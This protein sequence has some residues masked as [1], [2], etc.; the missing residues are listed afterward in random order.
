MGTQSPA[1]ISR[2]EFYEA[3]R[4]GPAKPSP[5]PR[6]QTCTSPPKASPR[7]SAFCLSALSFCF[8]VGT[9]NVRSDGFLSA[10]TARPRPALLCGRPLRPSAV[11]RAWHPPPLPRPPQPRSVLRI[12]KSVSDAS[13]EGIAEYLSSDRLISLSKMSPGALPDVTSGRK[14]CACKAEWRPAARAGPGLS[15][16][17]PACGRLGCLL[18][19]ANDAAANRCGAGVSPRPWLRFLWTDPA[20]E[21]RIAGRFCLQHSEA[22][23]RCRP[24]RL[25]HLTTRQ[26]STAASFSA[27]SATLVKMSH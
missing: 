13:Y 19:L 12:C 5:L 14:S 24:Q 18:A 11:P 26:Q 4:H 16:P 17:P 6:S 7:P 15:P 3:T 8:A 20:A 21:C 10:H 23:P 25:L 1:R 2:V 27:S 9:L 22:P